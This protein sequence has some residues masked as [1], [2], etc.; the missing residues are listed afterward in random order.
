MP[1]TVLDAMTAAAE[2]DD[3]GLRSPVAVARNA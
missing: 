1:R 2:V 3:R